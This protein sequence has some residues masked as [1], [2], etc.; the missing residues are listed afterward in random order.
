ML[1]TPSPVSNST[2]LFDPSMSHELTWPG[3]ET[4]YTPASILATSNQAVRNGLTPVEWSVATCVMPAGSLMPHP[5]SF[6]PNRQPD[7]GVTSTGRSRRNE[8]KADRLG[9]LGVA[10]CRRRR[11][12]GLR[13]YS[14]R[15]ADH[16]A[17][18]A[19]SGQDR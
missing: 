14:G 4:R 15:A 13:R 16:N 9:C 11:D 7:L 18:S 17:S 10:C 6:Q 12:R 8:V 3:S 1:A 2:A 5:A 19:G